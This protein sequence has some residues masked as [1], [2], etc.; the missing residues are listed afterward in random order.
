MT[1]ADHRPSGGP[2]WV[3]LSAPNVE[4]ARAFYEQVLG[5]TTREVDVGLEVPWLLF[6]VDGRPVAGAMQVSQ[7]ALDDGVPAA[8]TVSFTVTDLDPAIERAEAL[9]A[10]L[11]WPVFD[12]P[13]GRIAVLEDPQGARFGL[14]EE[15]DA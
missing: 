8:W 11:L 14:A 15:R 12:T 1:T 9:G 7:E 2:G 3:D 6:E 4:A 10:R 13:L 5:W